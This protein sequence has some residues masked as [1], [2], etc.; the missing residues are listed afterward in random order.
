MHGKADALR[1]HD[2]R[3]VDADHFAAR[4]HER[5]A[6]IAGIERRIG[7]DHVVDQPAVPRAQRAAERRDDA[8]RDRRLEAERIAD[9]DRR[10][11]RARNVFESPSA[12]AVVA[13]GI[14][15]RSSARSV[16]GSSPSS[17]AVEVRAVGGSCTRRGRL[18]DVAVGEH[19]AVGR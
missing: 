12:A 7:L 13:R 15:T 6:G 3:R 14:S 11:G 1:A 8:G 19:Q 2:H 16:S 5:P 10:G 9:R 4:R 17:A 18:H